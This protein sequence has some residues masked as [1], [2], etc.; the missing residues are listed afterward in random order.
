MREEDKTNQRNA[1]HHLPNHSALSPFWVIPQNV[2]CECG[3][4]GSSMPE[5][6][7][8]LLFIIISMDLKLTVKENGLSAF[9]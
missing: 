3:D 6:K 4:G 5:S 7:I 1:E 2:V 8:Y 9:F